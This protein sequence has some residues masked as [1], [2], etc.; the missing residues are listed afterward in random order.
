MKPNDPSNLQ[1]ISDG[2]E[3]A[4]MPVTANDFKNKK[5]TLT[6][7]QGEGDNVTEVT[8][9]FDFAALAMNTTVSMDGLTV[10]RYTT[11]TNE[12]SANEGAMTLYCTASDGTEIAVRTV[13]LHDES[14]NLITGEYFK[15]KT[16]SVKGMVDAFS[17][18]YQIKVFSLNDIIIK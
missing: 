14:G 5:I 1:K 7:L 2:N 9:T 16:V 15:G 17:G 3:A 4:Y 10:N 8:K 18:N 12:E 11:T 6:L 13:V